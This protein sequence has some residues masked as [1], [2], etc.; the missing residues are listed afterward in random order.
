M[1]TAQRKQQYWLGHVAGVEKYSGS[2]EAYCRAEGVSAPALRYWRKKLGR[3][4]R[5]KGLAPVT[6]SFIP[7]EVM[8][9][10]RTRGDLP[11]PR[12]L[13]ELIYHLSGGGR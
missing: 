6:P 8:S 5:S 4:N 2:H 13:A 12:W 11:D 7:V 1:R 9:E 3:V 10:R